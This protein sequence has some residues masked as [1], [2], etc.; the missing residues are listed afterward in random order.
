MLLALAV[1]AEHNL[2]PKLAFYT[3]S[4]GGIG[5][6]PDIEILNYRYANPKVTGPADWGLASGHIAQGNGISGTMLVGDSLYVKWRVPS[7]GKVY[8]DT[9]DLKSR[10][11]WSMDHKILHFSIKGPQLNIYL[12]E[13]DDSTQLHAI[14]APDCPIKVYKDFKC[15]RIYPDHWANF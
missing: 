1:A 12:V 2:G 5:E 11:P 3:F 6:S 4:Y 14:G 7:T 9:V 13:G 15:T 10:L 8:E